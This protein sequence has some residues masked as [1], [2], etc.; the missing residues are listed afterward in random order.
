MEYFRNS[1]GP[2]EKCLSDSGIDERNVHDVVLVGGN[3]LQME[4][5][6][7]KS[8]KGRD[9]VIGEMWKNKPPFCLAMNKATSDDVARRC[10]HYT[11]RGGMKFKSLVQPWP[12]IWE[13]LS[14]KWRNQSKPTIRLS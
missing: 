11:G 12:R 6:L 3:L 9:Y 13:C 8:W 4:A 7:P 1:M 2:T 10:K 14:R 5:V